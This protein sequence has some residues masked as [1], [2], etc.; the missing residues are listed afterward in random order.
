MFTDLTTEF[1]GRYRVRLFHHKVIATALPEDI[2]MIMNDDRFF[3]KPK[4]YGIFK[5]WLQDGLLTVKDKKKWFN[6]RKIL[7]PAFHFCILE[8]F[9]QIFLKQ[10]DILVDKLSHHIETESF[11]I[12]KYVTLYTLDVIC[13]TSMGVE[14]NAQTDE[15][16][17]YVNSINE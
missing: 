3:S 13:E 1:N 2:S 11:D 14:V 10:S 4:D 9:L 17:T 12:C 7:T 16:S 15:K 8:D 5:D 6:R